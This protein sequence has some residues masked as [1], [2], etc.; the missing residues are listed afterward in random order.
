MTCSQEALIQAWML[1]AMPGR[2][3]QSLSAAQPWRGTSG[4]ALAFGNS[5]PAAFSLCLSLLDPSGSATIIT[6]PISLAKPNVFLIGALGSLQGAWKRLS[7][8]RL[9]SLFGL[10][11]PPHPENRDH[12]QTDVEIKVICLLMGSSLTGLGPEHRR[13]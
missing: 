12:G 11:A 5:P 8:L 13:T 7:A 2:S 6:V 10:L 9:I 1:R 3:R 4:D